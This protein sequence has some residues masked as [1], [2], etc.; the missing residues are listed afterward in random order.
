MDEFSYLSVLIGLILGLGIT[1]LMEGVGHLVQLRERIVWY[2]P[3]KVW[4]VALLVFHLQA[5]W[6][7]YE[8]RHISDWTFTAFLIVLIQPVMLFF[9]SA[10][11]LPDVS[12]I[13]RIDLRRF[14]TE[15]AS[16]TFRIATLM[17]FSS[18][19]KEYCLYHRMPGLTNLAFHAL[20]LSVF[21][22]GSFNGG[23]MRYKWV[24]S[25]AVLILFL[26]ITLLFTKLV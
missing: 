12:D 1:K 15:H 3:L 22:V 21:L 20:F 19:L 25:S 7:M 8:L 10:L 18:L 2:W 26:Y 13:Q 24:V 6:A 23:E 17:V 11:A 9:L 14:F 5:W 4:V 16:F